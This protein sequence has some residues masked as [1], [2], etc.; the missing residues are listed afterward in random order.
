MPNGLWPARNLKPMAEGVPA[1]TFSKGDILVFNSNSSL[2]RPAY[3]ALD[4]LPIAG[5]AAAD[6]WQS[7]NNKVPYWVADPETVWWSAATQGSAHTKGQILDFDV[8]AAG[9]PVAVASVATP[10]FV[11]EEH[12]SQMAD[13]SVQSKVLGRFLVTGSADTVKRLV[14]Y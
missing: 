12:Q 5:V 9:R 10:R 4:S 14:A 1:S 8:N 6:S 7:W 2:S 3:A 11:V 13:A